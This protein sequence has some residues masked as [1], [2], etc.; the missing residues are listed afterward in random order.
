MNTATT[1]ARILIV[2]DDRHVRELVRRLLERAGYICA[3]AENGFEARRL[4]TARAFEL[5]ATSQ[6]P[7]DRWLR[8]MLLDVYKLDLTKPAGPLPEQLLDWSSDES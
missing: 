8:D 4:L 1:P 5:M 3:T 6:D 7:F 2:D